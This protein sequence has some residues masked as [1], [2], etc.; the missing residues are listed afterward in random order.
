MMEMPMMARKVALRR[1]L[2]ALVEKMNK[3][4]PQALLLARI[5][6]EYEIRAALGEPFYVDRLAEEALEEAA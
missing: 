4:Q 2:A 5:R 3:P 6:R 1:E